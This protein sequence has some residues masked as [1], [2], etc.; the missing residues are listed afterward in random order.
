MEEKDPKE[1]DGGRKKKKAVQEEVWAQDI[2]AERQCHSSTCSKCTSVDLRDQR[3]P[4]TTILCFQPTIMMT[5]EKNA[6]Y[7]F[8]M[9]ME[10]GSVIKMISIGATSMEAVDGMNTIL[11]R[12]LNLQIFRQAP[13]DFDTMDME[14]IEGRWMPEDGESLVEDNPKTEP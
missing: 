13:E 12:L 7:A 2:K 3:S 10:D 11:V 9:I 6:P 1:S 4:K 8:A 5:P 14:P